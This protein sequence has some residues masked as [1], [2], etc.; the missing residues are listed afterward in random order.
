MKLFRGFD[1]LESG[2][3]DLSFA[4]GLDAREDQ[5]DVCA[6]ASGVHHLSVCLHAHF[7]KYWFEC[8]SDPY[9]CNSRRTGIGQTTERRLL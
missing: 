3:V 1:L 5:V 9:E 7:L 6:R 2:K 4:F 8:S